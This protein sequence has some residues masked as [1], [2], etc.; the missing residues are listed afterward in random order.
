MQCFIAFYPRAA[1]RQA[2]MQRLR[3]NSKEVSDADG[4]DIE[5]DK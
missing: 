2:K 5:A 4:H 3:R 1:G